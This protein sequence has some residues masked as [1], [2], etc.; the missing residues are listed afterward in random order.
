[1]QLE[2]GLED[3]SKRLAA[4]ETIHYY[5]SNPKHDFQEHVPGLLT[6]GPATLLSATAR[7]ITSCH[8]LNAPNTCGASF[9]RV[10]KDHH[11]FDFQALVGLMMEEDKDTL[12]ACWTALGAVI[13]SIPKELQPSYVRTMSEAVQVLYTTSGNCSRFLSFL[14]SV[15]H[16][17]VHNITA[18]QPVV[19]L[20][21]GW[22]QTA[23]DKERR[24]RKPG[25][26]LLA[27]FC[28]PKALQ[29]VLPIYLQGMLQVS[30]CYCAF[31]VYDGS[32]SHS[33]CG[34]PVQ[35]LQGMVEHARCAGL[36]W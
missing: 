8:L 10:P 35:S 26:L 27:G 12:M 32:V 30:T 22:S 28:L 24:K 21:L 25:P 13:N 4:A 19:N 11:G 33:Y 7:T 20:W 29:P 15:I 18:L 6:V 31:L 23:R 1:M 9:S 16:L 3:P 36:L 5:C 17:A 34:Y 2:K 14:H